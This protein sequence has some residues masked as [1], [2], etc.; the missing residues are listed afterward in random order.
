MSR[1]LRCGFGSRALLAALVI[2]ASPHLSPGNSIA[3]GETTGVLRDDFQPP[4]GIV[5][6]FATFLT[7]VSGVSGSGAIQ[8][9]RSTGEG[10]ELTASNSAAQSGN[11]GPPRIVIATD[12]TAFDSNGSVDLRL[13]NEFTL[14]EIGAEPEQGFQINAAFANFALTG[15]FQPV[16]EGAPPVAVPLPSA[17]YAG[18]AVLVVALRFARQFE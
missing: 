9:S 13:A 12:A 3:I 6:S 17:A 5:R 18:C 15:T 1:H 4:G 8:L 10:A 11:A 2:L 7:D 14:H 16:A